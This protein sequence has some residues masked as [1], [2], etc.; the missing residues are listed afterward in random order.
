MIQSGFFQPV[1][2]H[3]RI[4]SY[5]ISS[6]IFQTMYHMFFNRLKGKSQL[7]HIP[8]FIIA[9]TL[10]YPSLDVLRVVAISDFAVSQAEKEV[11][12]IELIKPFG[13]QI[14][15]YFQ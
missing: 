6:Y 12:N 2:F 10:R 1:P 11:V 15:I 7:F 13:N 4:L 14:Q 3:D 5:F 8:S 9:L